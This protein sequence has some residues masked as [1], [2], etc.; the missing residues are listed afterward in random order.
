MIIKQSRVRSLDNLRFI[1]QGETVVLGVKMEHIPSSTLKQI[2]FS[3]NPA[4]GETVL[5]AP[6]GPISRY[7]AD[8]KVV[9]HKDLPI[10]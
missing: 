3:N 6:F 2:G 5:P 4:N 7:N 10:A 8:G 9:V 1:H